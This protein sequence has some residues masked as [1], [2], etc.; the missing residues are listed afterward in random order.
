LRWFTPDDLRQHMA[1]AYAI[2][3]LDA[4]DG[5]VAARAHDGVHMI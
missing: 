2:R 4:L 5:G 3:V 1:P